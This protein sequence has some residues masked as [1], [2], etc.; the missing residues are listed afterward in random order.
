MSKQTNKQKTKVI[1]IY[2]KKKKK[3][4]WGKY[5]RN[6]KSTGDWLGLLHYYVGNEV[7]WRDC[8]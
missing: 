6:V 5:T 7:F 2:K 3:S 4:P 8:K 1:P